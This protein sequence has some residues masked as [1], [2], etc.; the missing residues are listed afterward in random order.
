MWQ[1]FENFLSR[2]RI[3][4]EKTKPRK[5]E[6]FGVSFSVKVSSPL[7]NFDSQ[8]QCKNQLLSRYST[9]VNAR[10]NRLRRA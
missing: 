2:H 7:F 6:N 4:I 3:N 1:S 9:D 8:S 5:L 10:E